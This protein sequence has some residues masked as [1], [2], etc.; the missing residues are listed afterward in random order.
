[1]TAASIS[2]FVS[3]PASATDNALVRF[4]G[5]SGKLIKNNSSLKLTDNG[6]F[7]P[8]TDNGSAIKFNAA[9]GTRN[10]LSLD[11]LNNRIN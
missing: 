4:D 8:I 1:M 11:T 3:G 10:I 9:N 7:Y 5:V 6:I 2:N